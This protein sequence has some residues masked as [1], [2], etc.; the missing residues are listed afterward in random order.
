MK[1]VRL[2]DINQIETCELGVPTP[3]NDEILIK[4]TA[5]GINPVDWKIASGLLGQLIQQPLPMTLGWDYAGEVI[6]T[7]GGFLKGD[8]VY[9]M[10]PI[11]EDGTLSEYCAV[12]RAHLAQ[13]PE[14]ISLTEAASVPMVALTSWQALFNAGNVRAKQRVLI[15]AGAGGVGSFAIQLAKVVGA[16]VITTTSEANREFVLGLGADEVIDYQTQD[17]TEVLAERPVDVVLE[18]QSG[19][20]QLDAIK[21]LK[22]KGRLVSISGLSPETVEAAKAANVMASFVFVQY[23]GEQL[24]HIAE[25]IDTNQIKVT[26]SKQYP[27]EQIQAAYAESKTGHVRGKLVAT[28]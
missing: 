27:A 24:R 5:V 18:S 14:S 28:F 3:K 9:G 2:T 21:I 19:E 17:V 11:G 10:K 13:A 1:A 23:N 25:L 12:K 15:Q 8:K 16:Y 4:I 22:P 26:V 20:F 7:G 6:N